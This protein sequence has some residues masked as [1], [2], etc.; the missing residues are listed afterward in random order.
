MEK[1]FKKYGGRK[2]WS[3]I[4]ASIISFSNFYFELGLDVQQLLITISPLL[5][6]IGMEGFGDALERL[7][8]GKSMEKISENSKEVAEVAEK[9]LEED[10]EEDKKEE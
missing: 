10:S 8:K 6:F 4:V 9:F 5:G 3:G 2:L 7:S 1:F